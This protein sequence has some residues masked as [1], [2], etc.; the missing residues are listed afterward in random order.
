[1][2][3]SRIL[4]NITTMQDCNKNYYEWFH[5]N[6]TSICDKKHEIWI[7]V[8]ISCPRLFI[9]VFLIVKNQIHTNLAIVKMVASMGLEPMTSCQSNMR[10][11]NWA[12]RLL[13]TYIILY[14]YDNINKLIL[15]YKS[16]SFLIWSIISFS[17]E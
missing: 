13:F 17:F 15:N 10:S 1:M 9:W 8:Q 2:K 5:V 16:K 12:M 6:I 11:T 4:L 14:Y 3:L 7:F